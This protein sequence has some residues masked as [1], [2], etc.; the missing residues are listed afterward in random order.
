MLKDLKTTLTTQPNA[1]LYL[2]ALHTLM[3]GD[4]ALAPGGTTIN[5]L[6]Y[7]KLMTNVYHRTTK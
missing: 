5:T 7:D 6:T 1:S 3:G 2:K 4:K